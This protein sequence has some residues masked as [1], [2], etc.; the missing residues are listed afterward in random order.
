MPLSFLLEQSSSRVLI[1]LEYD[2]QG[3]FMSG[4]FTQE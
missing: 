2:V 3:S 1:E 4:I